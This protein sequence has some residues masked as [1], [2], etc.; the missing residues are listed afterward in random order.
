MIDDYHFGSITI[1]GKTFTSDIIL[2]GDSLINDSWWRKEGHSM[3]IEDLKE[4]PDQF[5]VLVIGSGASGCCEVPDE[6]VAHFKEKGD[7]I[8]RMTEEAT[9]K[10]NQLLAE[11]K[12]VIGAFH[13]TC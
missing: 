13:L 9:K 11:D 7:V 8:V 1:N 6:T 3:S 5:E 4:L 2:H 10:Y 12:D